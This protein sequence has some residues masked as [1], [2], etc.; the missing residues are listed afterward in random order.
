MYV[1]I[2]QKFTKHKQ[3]DAKMGRSGGSKKRSTP[4][5]GVGSGEKESIVVHRGKQRKGPRQK[6]IQ[7]EVEKTKENQGNSIPSS[8]TTQAPP[9]ETEDNSQ[10][11][12][13]TDLHMEE[14]GVEGAGGLTKEVIEEI[15][16]QSLMVKVSQ[17]TDSATSSPSIVTS[18]NLSSAERD[19][20]KLCVKRKLFKHTKLIYDERQ[21]DLT[22][23]VCHLLFS[24]FKMNSLSVAEKEA[25]WT[26]EKRR[27]VRL[28]LNVKRN[29]VC[30]QMKEKFWRKL[31]SCR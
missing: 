20:I 16:R 23:K 27:M 26:S 11:I 13:S 28:E 6:Q 2:D 21:L 24:E 15:K 18:W 30:N 5:N 17:L 10:G 3:S 25:W 31:T 4:G 22:G 1:S 19:M 12:I 7:T 29:N 8:I 9:A 14:D